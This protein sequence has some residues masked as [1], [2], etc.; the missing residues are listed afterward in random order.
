MADWL[1]ITLYYTA[2]AHGSPNKIMPQIVQAIY[3][4]LDATQKPVITQS[5]PHRIQP[6]PAHTAIAWPTKFSCTIPGKYTPSSLHAFSSM[7]PLLRSNTTNNDRRSY[8]RTKRL[9]MP[10]YHVISLAISL[11]G[12][13]PCAVLHFPF[14]L[15]Y[16]QMS[17]YQAYMTWMCCVVQTSVACW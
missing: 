11:L 7:P 16:P 17:S 12:L 14:N 13:T 15:S 9:P 3:I 5:G 2:I 4:W 10:F 8:Y 1:S 6:P